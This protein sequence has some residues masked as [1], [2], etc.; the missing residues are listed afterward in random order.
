MEA[1]KNI[2]HPIFVSGMKDKTIGYK[3][4]FEEPA[5]FLTGAKKTMFNI[6]ALLYQVAPII[7]VTIWAY[8]E[9][10]WWL[11]TGICLSYLFSYFAAWSKNEKAGKWKSR[12]IWVYTLIMIVYWIWK[13][14]HI[15]DMFTFLYLCAQ[16]GNY[17]FLVS[18]NIQTDYLTDSLIKDSILFNKL[19]S[20]GSI[21]IIRTK[22]E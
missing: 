5:K 11:L 13:G 7:I 16:W 9:N 12:L 20:N 21:M 3:V 18:E 22:G 8:H 4:M 14:F 19:I 2:P 6:F 17:L 1:N 15:H 10:N